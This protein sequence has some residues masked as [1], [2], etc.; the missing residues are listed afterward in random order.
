MIKEEEEEDEDKEEIRIERE[1]KRKKNERQIDAR[2]EKF[3][4]GGRGGEIAP[5]DYKIILSFPPHHT[6]R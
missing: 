4:S 5:E 3:P 2:A 1:E 6:R